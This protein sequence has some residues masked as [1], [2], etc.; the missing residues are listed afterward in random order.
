MLWGG[1]VVVSMHLFDD[2]LHFVTLCKVSARIMTGSEHLM[3]FMF[4]CCAL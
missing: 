4:L 3:D 2:D 1:V